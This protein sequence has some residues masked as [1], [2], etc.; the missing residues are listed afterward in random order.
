MSGHNFMGKWTK[1]FYKPGNSI[2]SQRK[3]RGIT[4]ED[5]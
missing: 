5:P 4:W 2:S 1:A 3:G